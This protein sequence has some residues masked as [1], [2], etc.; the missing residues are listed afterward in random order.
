[1]APARDEDA[2]DLA[3]MAELQE[4]VMSAVRG[5]ITGVITRR[6]SDLEL[7]ELDL[8]FSVPAV[9]E[10]SELKPVAA[11]NALE[12]RHDLHAI[13]ERNMPEPPARRLPAGRIAAVI[14]IVSMA[15]G[16]VAWQIEP[17]RTELLD[18]ARSV[19][20][21]SFTA[22]PEQ[23]RGQG[24]GARHAAVVASLGEPWPDRIGTLYADIGI[25]AGA[26]ATAGTALD[27][28][29]AV[30]P[31]SAGRPPDIRTTPGPPLGVLAAPATTTVPVL[32]TLGA[33]AAASEAAAIAAPAAVT[34]PGGTPAG[35]ADSTDISHA[36]HLLD[37]GAI[38]QA[39]Q[40]L[41]AHATARQSA[42]VALALARSYDPNF[43]AGLPSSDA[44]PDPAEA[45]RWYRR[46]YEIAVKEGLIS[47]T[48][49]LERVI[50]AMR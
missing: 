30:S 34:A 22:K 43:I 26:A 8:D 42:D 50:R 21:M 6:V 1:V 28:G 2:R 25:P 10:P 18:L 49:P 4:E 5:A 31:T 37:S 35:P 36:A 32:A 41:Q 23:P 46:W 38:T 7:P 9:V 40:L 44:A 3:G 16:A 14:T 12:L 13:A 29:P 17:V 47:E 39:R 11:A 45:E 33:E 27:A 20:A 15:A 19:P 48:V 24:A